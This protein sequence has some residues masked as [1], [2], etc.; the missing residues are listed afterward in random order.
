LYSNGLG[1][2]VVTTKV[3]SCLVPSYRG[4]GLVVL[5]VFG[6]LMYVVLSLFL[7]NEMTHRSPALFEKK[8]LNGSA[9]QEIA[10]AV[11]C[12]VGRRAIST[13]TVAQVLDNWQWVSDIVNP[14]SPIGLH[15]YLNLWDAMRG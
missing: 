1:V 11:V 14:L 8:L 2:T 5:V 3:F 7:L 12:M 6:H 13:R 4:K 15:Q 10:P 9:I